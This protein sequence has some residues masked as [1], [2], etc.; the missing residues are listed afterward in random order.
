VDREIAVHNMDR[1]S[2]LAHK[3]RG[4]I[5]RLNDGAY[6]VCLKCEENIAPKRLKAIPWAELCIRCQER[7]DLSASTHRAGEFAN[8]FSE[9]A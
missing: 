4:A 3:L 7:A 2:T 6:G 5:E 8:D 9:A 1:E